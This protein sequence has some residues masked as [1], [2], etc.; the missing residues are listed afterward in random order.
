[1]I[2]YVRL[3]AIGTLHNGLGHRLEHNGILVVLCCGI[4]TGIIVCLHLLVERIEGSGDIGIGPLTGLVTLDNTLGEGSILGHSIAELGRIDHS[5]E[6]GLVGIEECLVQIG[7]NLVVGNSDI[8]VIDLI[9]TNGHIAQ[10]SELRV[11]I[12]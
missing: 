6:E 7:C 8:I 2:P 5:L 12:L 1:M 3:H 4:T 11:G 9:Q 10:R